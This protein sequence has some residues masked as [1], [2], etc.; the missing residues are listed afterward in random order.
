MRS[1]WTV[2]AAAALALVAGCGGGD[3]ETSASTTAVASGA[4]STTAE[5]TTTVPATTTTKAAESLKAAL[6]TPA[7]VPGSTAA[8]TTSAQ[9]DFD[10]STCI[11]GNSFAT[12][13]DPTEVKNPGLELTVGGVNRQYG[14]KARQGSPEQAQAFVTAFGS[15]AGAAC[16][17]DAFKR[18]VSEDPDPPKIDASDLSG[19]GSTAAVG[20]GGGMLSLSGQL[21]VGTETVATEADL[22][23]FQKGSVVVFVSAS[24]VGGAKVP[25]QAVDLAKKINGR[26]P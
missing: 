3:S 4:P 26:L 23:V 16:V 14:A 2:V 7:D 24:A 12:K 1:T 18:L 15:P 22:L 6:L 17:L 25:G 21:K 8:T 11:P 19:T 9:Q 5:V 13:T 20:D 10:L